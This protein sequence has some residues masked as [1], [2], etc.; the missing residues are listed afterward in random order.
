M[1]R[2]TLDEALQYRMSPEEKA[3]LD[4]MT[5]DDIDYSDIPDQSDRKDWIRPGSILGKGKEIVTLP[6]DSD[7]LAFFRKKG[8]EYSTLMNA[9]LR[10]YVLAQSAKTAQ[11]KGSPVGAG[12]AAGKRAS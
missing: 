3:R 6:F 4:A 10:E 12:V 11:I 1:V 5:D 9:V 8:R 2:I 7:V